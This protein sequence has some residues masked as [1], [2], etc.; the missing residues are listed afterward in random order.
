MH[1]QGE[2]CT[3]SF[4]LQFTH[5]QVLLSGTVWL[6]PSDAHLRSEPTRLHFRSL[7]TASEIVNLQ[8][9]LTDTSQVSFILP[10]PIRKIQRLADTG[11]GVVHL[12]MEYHQPEP[13]WW[14]WPVTSPLKIHL[15]IRP[16]EFSYLLN[17]LN[18]ES[19]SA[20]LSW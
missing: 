18:R 5:E 9:W 3:L 17:S 20:D 10:D 4:G 14:A 19:W 2:I 8:H 7:L 6:R 11:D 13:L 16:N 1:F 15:A 12:E